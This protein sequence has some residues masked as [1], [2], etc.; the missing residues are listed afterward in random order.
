MMGSRFFGRALLVSLWCLYPLMRLMA[1]QNVLMLDE[2]DTADRISTAGG[3]WHLVT[4]GVMGG[5]SEGRLT[6]AVVEG[7]RCLRLQGAVRIENNGGF[8]QG[9][10]DV[11]EALLTRITGYRGVLLE[12]Y[13]NAEQY[14]VH[15]RTRDLRLPWQSYRTT[16]SASPQ[17]Q[18]L[19]L[20]FAGFEPYR[21]GKALD[22]S[23]LKRIGI[24]AIGRA[25]DADVCIGKIG[26]YL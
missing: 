23:R 12:V 10:V 4:D 25:F 9:A 18:T 14:N 16:F 24:V 7:R 1:E 26:F 3:E 2:R 19:H 22:T 6:P 15:L 17:W 21:T 5:I 8:I 20:P 11:P 13:G